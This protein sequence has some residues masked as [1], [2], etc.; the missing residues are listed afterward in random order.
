MDKEL[1][2][3]HY[4]T[5]GLPVPFKDWEIF[6]I[7]VKDNY[8]WSD[9]VDILT[10]EKN[11]INDVKI[12]QMSYLDFVIMLGV[13][14]NS[15]LTKLKT[16][17][18]LCLGIKDCAIDLKIDNNT[19]IGLII[20]PY[21]I[22]KDGEEEKDYFQSKEITAEDFD[23]IKRIILF[24]NIYDYS[25][26]YIDPDVKKAIDEYYSV[27]NRNT[28][29]VSMEDKIITVLSSTAITKQELLEMP[30]RHF[31]LL[32][33][34]VVDKVDYTIMQLADCFPDVK[35]KKPIEH[36]VYKQKHDKYKEAFVDYDAMASKINGTNF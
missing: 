15:Y 2:L 25:D 27:S 22:N 3:N 18:E 28:P 33:N 6:P 8:K 16:I 32:F 20:T 31:Y 14:D 23:E 10:I 19:V 34:T 26:E 30:L 17:L 1:L 36:W 29:Q 35:F 5:L 21:I 24:Q 7:K 11:T 9:S 13:N 12:I 4:I